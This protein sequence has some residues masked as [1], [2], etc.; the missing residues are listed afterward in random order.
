MRAIQLARSCYLNLWNLKDFRIHN[1]VN[2]MSLFRKQS[3]N[4]IVFKQ[5][6][7]HSATLVFWNPCI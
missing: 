1:F 2:H 6:Q 4:G 3:A 7:R 5:L